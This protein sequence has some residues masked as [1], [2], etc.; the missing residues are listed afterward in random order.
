M[1]ETSTLKKVLDTDGR[2]TLRSLFT[3]QEGEYIVP[4][5]VLNDENVAWKEHVRAKVARSKA[6]MASRTVSNQ[7]AEA[8]KKREAK[9]VAMAE[10]GITRQADITVLLN[11]GSKDFRDYIA[12]KKIQASMGVESLLR[13]P[14]VEYEVVETPTAVDAAIEITTPADIDNSSVMAIGSLEDALLGNGLE[15]NIAEAGTEVAVPIEGVIDVTPSDFDSGLIYDPLTILQ[16]SMGTD[17]DT[18]TTAAYDTEQKSIV[19]EQQVV[20]A[21]AV[22]VSDVPKIKVKEAWGDII[23]DV[24]GDERTVPAVPAVATAPVPFDRDARIAR[25]VKA[26]VATERDIVIAN[27]HNPDN[28]DMLPSSQKLKKMLSMSKNIIPNRRERR[29]LNLYRKEERRIK[30]MYMKTFAW[31]EIAGE[32]EGVHEHNLTTEKI[33]Y[34]ENLYMKDGVANIAESDTFMP[35]MMEVS[36]GTYK[37]RYGW[38]NECD[39]DL[40]FETTITEFLASTAGIGDDVATVVVDANADGGATDITTVREFRVEQTHAQT[41][42]ANELSMSGELGYRAD[43]EYGPAKCPVLVDDDVLFP[44]AESDTVAGH[45]YEDQPTDMSVVDRISLLE[46]QVASIFKSLGETNKLESVSISD[47]LAS[48]EMYIAHIN[49]KLGMSSCVA[50]VGGAFRPPASTR[51]LSSARGHGGVRS[52]SVSQS[53]SSASPG[54]NRSRSRQSDFCIETPAVSRTGISPGPRAS[55]AGGV[56]ATV[57][58]TEMLELPAMHRNVQLMEKEVLEALRPLPPTSQRVV[59]RLKGRIT[60]ARA[61][62]QDD[63]TATLKERNNM[64]MQRHDDRRTAIDKS[65]LNFIEKDVLKGDSVALMERE[66]AE[67]MADAA[68][69]KASLLNQFTI[70]EFDAKFSRYEIN[71]SSEFA[72]SPGERGLVGMRPQLRRRILAAAATTLGAGVLIAGSY[73]LV[74]V[75]HDTSDYDRHITSESTDSSMDSNEGYG[76]T[77]GTPDSHEYVDVMR[78]EAVEEIAGR[79]TTDEI[80][81]HMLKLLYDMSREDLAVFSSVSSVV[82]FVAGEA[83]YAVASW[84]SEPTSK[85]TGGPLGH[86]FAP[87]EGRADRYDDTHTLSDTPSTKVASS[88]IMTQPPT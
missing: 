87:L 66:L 65:E 57:S 20:A 41:T 50:E 10:I 5:N 45:S 75:K 25:L 74:S 28:A 53:D 4:A 49:K 54:R 56:S 21:S 84:M 3:V 52:R 59:Q 61:D 63:I 51:S 22:I 11:L 17:L 15:S 23:D 64:S 72:L 88:N 37:Q 33:D 14:I 86:E 78:T 27:I 13:A 32:L 29:M 71:N 44:I 40:D 73:L 47:R 82:G 85:S 48:L 60:K 1:S 6:L 46:A 55:T 35:P 31:S 70:K 2:Q 69:Q 36:Q 18:A 83:R 62:L 81:T 38:S 30:S 80:K 67:Y 34:V 76:P 8:A 12:W 26:A 43:V 16:K 9:I 24:D 39:D 42:S 19:T 79:S 77:D 68:S 58:V 7:F